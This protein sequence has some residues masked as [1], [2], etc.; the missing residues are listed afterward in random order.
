MGKF[1]IFHG[2]GCLRLR[3]IHKY[4]HKLC[5]GILCKF[6]CKRPHIDVHVHLCTCA[7]TMWDE[8]K[9]AVG[10]IL[11]LHIYVCH[12]LNFRITAITLN[13]CHTNT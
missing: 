9:K 13:V 4:I 5:N 1:M 7:C 10:I 6:C 11:L 2:T 12:V 8:K 3:A